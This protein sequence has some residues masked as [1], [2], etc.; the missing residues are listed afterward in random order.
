[1]PKRLLYNEII[2]SSNAVEDSSNYLYL[3]PWLKK[4]AKYFQ[5]KRTS[6]YVRKLGNISL[7]L[8][9]FLLKDPETLIKE[10]NMKN[11]E[12]TDFL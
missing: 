11:F 8:T 9:E 4:K 12:K 10:W 2:Q 5:S 7:R 1:M 3:I 6:K